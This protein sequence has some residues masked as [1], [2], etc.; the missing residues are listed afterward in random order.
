M[1]PPHATPLTAR[2]QAPAC[3][4][5]C[6]SYGLLQGSPG[7]E[8]ALVSALSPTAPQHTDH[9]RGSPRKD[10]RGKAVVSGGS[11]TNQSPVTRVAR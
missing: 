9:L 7:C 6:H 8:E 2:L 3:T 5:R 1:G 11:S 4:R 10:Q